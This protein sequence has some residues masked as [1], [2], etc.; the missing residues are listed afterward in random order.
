MALLIDVTVKVDDT[1]IEDLYA[2]VISEGLTKPRAKLKLKPEPGP[3]EGANLGMLPWR[4][5]DRPLA[6]DIWQ[7]IQ[8]G[9]QRVFSVMLRAPGQRFTSD[10][11]A[12]MTDVPGGRAF[13]AA[14]TWPGNFC[15]DVGRRQFWEYTNGQYWIE[16]NVAAIFGGA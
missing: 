1:R 16:P 11:L 3:T 9:P 14:L 13:A 10:E 8:P 6:T 4:E 2:V 12:A 7:R 5:A 15:R